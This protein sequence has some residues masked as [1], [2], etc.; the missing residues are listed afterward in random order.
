MNEGAIQLASTL[1]SRQEI[2]ESDQPIK[3]EIINAT[4]MSQ[5]T[6]K[7]VSVLI[8]RTSRLGLPVDHHDTLQTAKQTSFYFGHCEAGPFT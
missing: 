5:L 2:I 3:L 7:W 1:K 8:G 4:N 6:V